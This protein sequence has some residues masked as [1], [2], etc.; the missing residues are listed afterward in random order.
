[1][2]LTKVTYVNGTTV[3]GAQNLNDIQDEIIANAAS[4][5]EN[6]SDISTLTAALGDTDEAVEALDNRIDALEEATGQYKYGVSGINN[7]S[8]TLT[9]LWDA[10][11]LTAAVGTD[12]ATAVNDFDNRAPF[13]RRKCVGKWYKENGRAVFRVNA[14]LGDD[15]YAEDGTMGDY[16]AVECPLAYYYMKDGVLGVSAYPHAGWKPFDIFCHN[17]NPSDVMEKVYLPAYALAK[18]AS[19][20][21]VSLPGLTNEQGDYASL[22]A[23]ARTYNGDGVEELAMLQPAAVNFYEWALFTVEFATLNCQAIMQGCASLR[24]NDSDTCTFMDATHVL[25]AYQAARVVGE[26]IA[27][28]PSGTSQTAAAYQATHTITSIVRCDANGNA[29]SSGSYQLI[30]VDDLGK[31]YVTY[32]TTGAT[33]YALAARPW[34]T[35]ACNDVLTP[36][37]SPVSNTNGYYPMRYR[38]RENV[39]SNQYKTVVDLFNQRVADG[40]SYHLDWYCLPDPTI[41]TPASSSKPDATDLTS[42]TFRKLDVQTEVA[43]Y[44]SGYIRSKKYSQ[45]YPDIW[46]PYLTSGASAS[47][48]FCDYAYLV[49][50]ST[51]RSVRFGGSWYT[52]ASAGFSSA[53]AHSAPSTASAFYGGDLC[54]AQ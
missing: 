31:G 10:V 13:N 51:V 41:Y 5:G 19:G 3:I 52:G 40:S 38:Y 39:Y 20:K 2:A 46:I 53:I 21:A 23:A 12:T 8:P 17:H 30:G 6:A 47:T 4:I 33:T 15:D 45:I 36:S 9:R 28:T 50:S 29:S 11:G 22:L 14:Y 34:L 26:A 42:S 16:V 54:F 1:M 35:G 27:I 49:N 18:D 48:Y 44:V 37:G 43:N 25:T 24:S 7:S 32:D